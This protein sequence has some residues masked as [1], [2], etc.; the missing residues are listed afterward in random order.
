MF[1]PLQHNP[2]AM[3]TKRTKLDKSFNNL[4][5]DV[6]IDN[7]KARAKRNLS[8]SNKSPRATKSFKHSWMKISSG[9]C[10]SL[11]FQTFQIVAKS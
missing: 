9:A 4:F 11:S 3:I 6:S 10:L 1:C 5:S 2:Q 7:V 8:S